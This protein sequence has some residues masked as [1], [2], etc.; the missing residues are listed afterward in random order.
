[1]VYRNGVASAIAAAVITATSGVGYAALRQASNDSQQDDRNADGV[2]NVHAQQIGPGRP[3]YAEK[4]FLQAEKLSEAEYFRAAKNGGPR[5]LIWRGS[6][7]AH[8]VGDQREGNSREKKKK[9]RGDGSAKLRPFHH[10]RLARG[11][12]QP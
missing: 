6:F 8:F 2:Q 5:N 3:G 1:M 12:A 4:I 10:T 9:R 7:L 11:S